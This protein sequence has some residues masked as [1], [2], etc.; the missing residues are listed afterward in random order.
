MAK[1]PHLF[2]AAP[3]RV[4]RVLVDVSTKNTV[5]RQPKL[6]Q[7]LL[8]CGTDSCLLRFSHGVTLH[9]QRP[10]FHMLFVDTHVQCP[11]ADIL[12]LAVKAIM[13]GEPADDASHTLARRAL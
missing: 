2:G 12:R 13:F 10:D 6:V 9:R 1:S 4:K 3:T 5:E 8:H 11:V 7:C